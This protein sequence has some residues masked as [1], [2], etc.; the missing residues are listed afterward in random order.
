VARHESHPGD[1][2]LSGFSFAADKVI[3]VEGSEPYVAHFEFQA[4]PDPDLDRRVLV[5]NVLLRWRHGLPVRSVAVLLRPQAQSGSVTGQVR[6]LRDPA[7]RL[8][9]GYRLLRV[10]EQP[11]A[12]L[13]AGG[14]GTLP[15]APLAAADADQ[16]EQT[17]GE[18]VRR[19]ER[20][21]VVSVQ[22]SSIFTATYILLGLRYQREVAYHLMRGVRQMKES[23]TYQAI[24]EE[25]KQEGRAEEARAVLLRLGRKRLGPPD[26]ASLGALQSITDVD[27]LEGLAER[28]LEVSSWEELLLPGR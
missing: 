27:R 9:F 1:P 5:Y 14:L 25:G 12:T 26:A 2:E 28:V 17:V 6:D 20:E 13:L 16:A 19:L 11:V 10:W 21:S 22:A 18:M 15:L 3:R 23:T 24:L 4:S 8:D 7:G